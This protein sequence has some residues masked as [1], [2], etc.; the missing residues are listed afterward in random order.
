MTATTRT[1]HPNRIRILRERASL[2]QQELAHL[3]GLD[4]TTVAH[5]EAG[6][7]RPT[8]ANLQNY[9][10]VFKVQTWEILLD[11]EKIVPEEWQRQMQSR[12]QII[13]ILDNP[14]LAWERRLALVIEFIQKHV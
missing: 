13:E 9:A 3:T 10:R 14:A 7:R 12:S 8:P 1:I 11:P 4:F 6:S 2:T 5:H